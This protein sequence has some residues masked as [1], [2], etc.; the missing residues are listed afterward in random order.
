M[1]R[2]ETPAIVV[3]V[4]RVRESDLIL[5]LLTAE[6]G[7]LSASARGARKST[8]RYGGALEIGT[9]L[10]VRLARR[11]GAEMWSISGTDD[12]VPLSSARVDLD[13][14]HQVAFALEVARLAGR[15]G[16][17]DRRL[18]GLVTGFVDALERASATSA[19]T[20]FAWELAVLRHLGYALCLELP[21]GTPPDALSF[22]SGGAICRAVVRAPDAVA[23][24]PRAIAALAALARGDRD[25]RVP[26]GD[27]AAIHRAL[28]AIWTRA[29]G[30]SLRAS[31]F[32]TFDG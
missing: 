15:E 16:A 5:Q 8:R 27:A 28:D 32:V 23:V 14:F 19:E 26:D 10:T 17:C 6:T 22:D 25:A 1:Q 20:L 9:R 13:C 11:P 21:G 12:L 7:R 2:L 3:R 18:F 31:R 29:L 24:P 4:T 30:C